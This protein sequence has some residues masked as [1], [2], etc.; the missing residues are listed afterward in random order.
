MN[1]QRPFAAFDI[2]GTLVRWQLYH[3]VTDA[4][5]KLGYLEDDLYAT[6]RQARSQWKIRKHSEA[7]QA[8][9]LTMIR[10]FE[11]I[12]KTISV[13]QFEAAVDNVIEEYKDQVY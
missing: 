5:A 2:D 13:G 1:S 7:F 4:L 6:V 8:Y 3:A 10:A 11:Q 9:E 12:M